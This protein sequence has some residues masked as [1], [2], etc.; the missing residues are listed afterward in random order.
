MCRSVQHGW[1]RTVDSVLQ[2]YHIR[3]LE[4]SIQD[5][6]LLWVNRIV[7]PK[8]GRENLL[9]LFHE[10]HPG[11]SKMK[12]LAQDEITSAILRRRLITPLLMD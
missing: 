7:V 5:N 1:L 10:A 9:V 2:P 3:Q 11:I 4:L 12:G 6:C 8:Q